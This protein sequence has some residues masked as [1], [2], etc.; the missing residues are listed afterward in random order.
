MFMVCYTHI[1]HIMHCSL[2]ELGHSPYEERLLQQLQVQFT[3]T[4][5]FL[6]L[7]ALSRYILRWCSLCNR[8]NHIWHHSS[9]CTNSFL[10]TTDRLHIQIV[11]TCSTFRPTNL[12]NTG[13]LPCL[14]L[15]S[16]ITRGDTFQRQNNMYNGKPQ[17]WVVKPLLIVLLCIYS[18]WLCWLGA[19]MKIDV[20][21]V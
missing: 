12:P 14:S 5:L 18:I 7:P 4:I 6:A 15:R 10:N 11:A 20:N 17:R 3:A 2:E 9:S 1:V 13:T 21:D 8:D 19:G 16:K